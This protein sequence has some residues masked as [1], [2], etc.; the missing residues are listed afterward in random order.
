MTHKPVILIVDDDASNLEVLV[1]I[2]IPLYAVRVARS[3]ALAL[4]IAATAPHPDLILLD[5]GLL[6]MDGYAVLDQLKSS[7]ATRDIPVIF[8]TARDTTE[9]EEHGFDCGAVDY[10]TK[11]VRPPVVLARVHLHLSLL[12]A[13]RE[14]ADQNMRL[15]LI[16]SKF[17]NIGDGNLLPQEAP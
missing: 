13:Q 2:L 14:L 16:T 4:Q 1:H 11:P 8:V 6:D 5:I 9:D 15:A 12:Q 17:N 3:G 10:I 7:A